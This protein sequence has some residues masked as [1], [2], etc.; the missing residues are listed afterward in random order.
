G[1][2]RP[3]RSTVFML[4]HRL[5]S[6]AAIMSRGSD[7]A[8]SLNSSILPVF[9]ASRP[10]RSAWLSVNH[11]FPP[12][13]NA[14]PYGAAP[15]VGTGNSVISPLGVMRATLSAAISANQTLPSGPRRDA[16]R[17]GALVELNGLQ[18]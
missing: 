6:G 12:P 16:A 2:T 17:P 11:T 5:P 13:S 14:I 9:G 15:G 4:N 8:V 3:M 7:L 10:T 1:V 18:G